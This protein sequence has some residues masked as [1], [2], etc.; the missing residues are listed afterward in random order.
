MI[1]ILAALLVQAATPAASVAG[2]VQP[3]SPRVLSG[4]FTCAATTYEV[5]VTATPLAGTGVVLDRLAIGDHAVDAGSLAEARRMAVRLHDVQSIDV[6]CRED[7]AGELSLYGTQVS[8]DGPSRRARLRGM[9]ED[10]KLTGVTL[11]VQR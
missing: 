11:G 9:L 2:A 10:G 4:R 3:A 8:P 5:Q 6:R 1:P 7:G